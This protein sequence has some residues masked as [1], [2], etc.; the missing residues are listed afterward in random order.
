MDDGSCMDEPSLIGR[1]LKL[2]LVYNLGRKSNENLETKAA[3][4]QKKSTSDQ[5]WALQP[6]DHLD[7]TSLKDAIICP[8]PL[9]LHGGSLKFSIR[10]QKTCIHPAKHS[11]SDLTPILITRIHIIVLLMSR[12]GY[13]FCAAFVKITPACSFM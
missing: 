8:L 9:S 12:H 13:Y 4:F 6:T 5:L 1:S 10:I 2:N 7:F 3:K 11:E